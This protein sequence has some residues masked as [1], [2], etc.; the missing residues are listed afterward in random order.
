MEE[1]AVLADRVAEGDVALEEDG[2]AG[3]TRTLEEEE[4]EEEEEEGI[5]R[6]NRLM[7]STLE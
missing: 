1:A 5:H 7:V 3:G 6:Y 4:E 2:D